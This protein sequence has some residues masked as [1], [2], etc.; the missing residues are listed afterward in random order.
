MK[1]HILSKFTNSTCVCL[2]AQERTLE[3]DERER[4][5]ANVHLPEALRALLR[6]CNGQAS[7]DTLA[8]EFTRGCMGGYIVV[9]M[10][11][12]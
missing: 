3:F 2:C 4:S 8:D 9:S 11:A 5:A 6:V 10:A 1:F 7:P 12:F